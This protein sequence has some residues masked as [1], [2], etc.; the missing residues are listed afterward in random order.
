MGQR[1]YYVRKKLDCVMH[2]FSPLNFMVFFFF[3]TGFSSDLNNSLIRGLH[4]D[5]EICS[6]NI[7]KIYRMP[8]H[9]S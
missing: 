7:Y 8:H 9:T 1:E 6:G 3:L 4:I 5:L 2:N